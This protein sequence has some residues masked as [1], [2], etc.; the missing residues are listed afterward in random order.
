MPRVDLTVLA[1]PAFVGAMG[2]EY[3]WQRRRVARGGVPGPGDYELQDTLA[4]LTMGVGSLVAPFVAKALL[5]PLTPGRGRF[6][7]VLL[8]AAVVGA[9]ATTIADVVRRHRA[10][11]LPAPGAVPANAAPPD[12]VHSRVD[13]LGRLSGVAAVTA[14]GASALAAATTWAAVTS[15]SV[16]FAR[17]DRD[18]GTG[19]LATAVAIVGWDAIY[20]WNHRLSHERS[21]RS[22]GSRRSSTPQATTGSITAPT[23]SISTSTT[24]RSSSCGTSSSGPSSL[25][26]SGRS[27]G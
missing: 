7:R 15:G 22:A 8:G 17:H 4:S 27:M 3:W 10:G 20:Y 16:L 2:T 14:V 11:E 26:W 5:D 6:G 1:I 9:A 19:V 12:L 13:A 24:A 23:V 21:A 18:L 25:R